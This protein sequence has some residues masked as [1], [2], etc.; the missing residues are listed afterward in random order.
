MTSPYARDVWWLRAVGRL[1][2]GSSRAAAEVALQGIAAAIAAAE[3]AS[4]KS[5]GVLLHPVGGANPDD[6]RSLRA[7]ALL[8]LVP[9]SVLLIACANVTSLLLARGLSRHRE[10]AVRVALGASRGRLVRQFLAE[11]ATLAVVS[12]AASLLIAMWTPDLLIRLAGAP[13]AADAGPDIRVVAFAVLVCG[14]TTLAF[15]LL[16]ALRASSFPRSAPLRGGP[17]ST[18]ASWRWSCS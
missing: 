5:F 9:L 7:L 11:S 10:I 2:P 15:G 12:G 8:P 13:V 18:A 1:A 3:P 16:P 4:H 14:I 17:G 6:R